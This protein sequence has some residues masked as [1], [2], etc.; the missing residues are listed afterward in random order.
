MDNSATSSPVPESGS[1]QRRSGRVV[2]APQ[3]FSQDT[4]DTAAQ[5]KRKRTLDQDDDDVEN[6]APDSDEEMS[7]DLDGDDDD[8][9]HGR[10]AKPSRTRKPALKKPKTNGTHAAPSAHA[11]NLA[12]R[13]KK[14]VRIA[15]A[16]GDGTGLYGMG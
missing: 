8:A 16:P 10:R 9:P 4:T 1:R 11:T 14:S 5:P 13:P 2:R 6:E 7:D 12:R 3:K 15:S